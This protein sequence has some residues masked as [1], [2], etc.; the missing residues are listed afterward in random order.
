MGIIL[1]NMS[2]YMDKNMITI[3]AVGILA[4]LVAFNFMPSKTKKAA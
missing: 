3:V 1:G 2:K 4:V